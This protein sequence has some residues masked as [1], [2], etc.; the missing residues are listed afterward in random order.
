MKREFRPSA[1][2]DWPT[3]EPV[4]KRCSFSWIGNS[5]FVLQSSGGRVIQSPHRLHH[6]ES[7]ARS[8][9]FALAPAKQHQAKERRLAEGTEGPNPTH[10]LRPRRSGSRPDAVEGKGFSARADHFNSGNCVLEGLVVQGDEQ[11]TCAFVT[12][13]IEG[14]VH[15]PW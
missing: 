10:R 15:A 4:P 3:S 5:I 2:D 7:L 9:R 11:V 14:Y 6:G 13:R 1:M 8:A 12:L